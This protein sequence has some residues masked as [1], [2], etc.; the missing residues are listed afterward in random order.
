MLS[1]APPAPPPP[2]PKPAS[3]RTTE[4]AGRRVVTAKHV[5]HVWHVDLTAI[6]IGAPGFGFWAPWWPFA[7]LLR[8]ALSFHIALVVDHFSRALVAFAVF[9][10]EPSALEVCSLL[11]RAVKNAGCAPRYIII[12]KGSQFQDDHRA[13]CHRHGVRPRFGAVGQHG[14]IAVVERF[15]LS[16]KREFLWKILVP[17]S[18]ASMEQ[19]L[20]AYELWYNEHRPHERLDGRTPAEL[21]DGRGVP[22][23]VR[24]EPRSRMPLARA[25]PRAK[26]GRSLELRVSYLSGHRQLPVV[27]LRAA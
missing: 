26:R 5:H 25:G 27:E 15:I 20:A 17:F 12:D 1:R 11:E 7:L 19:A 2:K 24:L 13:W 22:K 14:S 9:R 23:R 18:K 10:H 16:L 6:A 21:R 3:T 4:K 8:W